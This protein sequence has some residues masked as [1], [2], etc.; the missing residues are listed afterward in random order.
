[1]ISLQILLTLIGF[2]FALFFLRR[3]ICTTLSVLACWSHEPIQRI[4]TYV[5]TRPR[6]WDRQLRLT[7]FV[8]DSIASQC[9]RSIRINHPY[10]RSMLVIP[11]SNYLMVVYDKE[12]HAEIRHFQRQRFYRIIPCGQWSN[13]S[14]RLY[15]ESEIA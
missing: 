3:I 14:R 9:N 1:M 12:P 7:V 2:V 13:L 8:V 10:S 5:Y 11:F 6:R 15:N 4:V